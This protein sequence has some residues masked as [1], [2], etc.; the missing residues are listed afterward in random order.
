MEKI[1]Q[2]IIQERQMIKEASEREE[3]AVQEDTLFSQYHQ[4]MA[5]YYKQIV[6]CINSYVDFKGT[7]EDFI[8]RIANQPI[9]EQQTLE[10]LR[11]RQ[12]SPY[13]KA[14]GEIALLQK[15]KLEAIIN[16]TIT[17]EGI[18]VHKDG[19]DL[20]AVKSVAELEEEGDILDKKKLSQKPIEL[21]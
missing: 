12:I 18:T 4:E 11:L 9:S 6:E 2:Y 5:D 13:K 10:F 1:N 17:N 21:I 3:K 8:I 16:F 20:K 14:L 7:D 19:K 15:E